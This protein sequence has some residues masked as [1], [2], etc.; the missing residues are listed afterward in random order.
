MLSLFKF[1]QQQ[2]YIMRFYAG[3]LYFQSFETTVTIPWKQ[4]AAA[5]S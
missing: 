5:G 3:G 4:E 1:I 2:V